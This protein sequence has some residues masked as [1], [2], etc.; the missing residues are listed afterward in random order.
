MST[1]LEQNHI[2]VTCGIIE[3]NGQ[4]LAAQRARWMRIPLKWEFPGGKIEPGESPEDCLIR[5]VME[6]LGG[7][8]KRLLR[9]QSLLDPIFVPFLSEG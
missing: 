1:E 6:E 3:S 5:E 2:H 9:L 4:V 7:V 8:M